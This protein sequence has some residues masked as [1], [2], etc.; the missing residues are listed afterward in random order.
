[1]AK[2]NWHPNNQRWLQFTPIDRFNGTE[3]N[4]RSVPDNE[5]TASFQLLPLVMLSVMMPE[6]GFCI[7]STR[8]VVV[9]N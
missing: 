5:N 2:T 4:R 8:D 1:M 7:S 6:A 9:S 3:E